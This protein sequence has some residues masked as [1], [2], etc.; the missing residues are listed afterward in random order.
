LWQALLAQDEHYN[1]PLW[2]GRE[3]SLPAAMVAE[4]HRLTLR[5]KAEPDAA[6]D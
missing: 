1:D 6:H 2:V 5:L 3:L 4:A